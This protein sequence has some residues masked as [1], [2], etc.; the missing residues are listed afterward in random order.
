METHQFN[1]NIKTQ[2]SDLVFQVYWKL[3]GFGFK[4]MTKARTVLKLRSDLPS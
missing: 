2:D 1:H 4:P 3:I